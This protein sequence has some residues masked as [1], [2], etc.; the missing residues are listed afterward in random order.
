[1]Y[2]ANNRGKRLPAALLSALLL[3]TAVFPAFQALAA[4]EGWLE[5]VHVEASSTIRTDLDAYNLIDGDDGT[6][7]SSAMRDGE[8]PSETDNVAF[9]VDGTADI[10]K[11]AITPR[12]DILTAFP[13]DFK[14][15]YSP[16]KSTWLDIPGQT[17]TDYQVTPGEKV[18][19]FQPVSAKRIR[20]VATRYGQDDNGAYL[21]QLGEVR[22]YGVITAPANPAIWGKSP[23]REPY[24]YVSEGSFSGKEQ[25][26]SPDPLV[27]YRWD[28]PKAEDSLE[29]FLQK[30]KTYDTET[31][32]S[33]AGL[34]TITTDD[35]AITV[36]GPGT[37]RMDFGTEFAGWLEIDSPDL[38]GEITLG[39]SEYNQPAFVNSG[40]KSPS[41]TAAP[42]K[43]GD[44]Y[45]LELNDELYEG[46]R[47]GFINVEKFD[48]PF[49]ITGVRL[50]CQTKPVN[51]GGSFDSDNEMLNK[52]WYTAAYD[53]RANLKKDYLAAILVDRGDRHS[54]TGDA[55][56]SQAA[57]LVAFGNYDFILE[58]LRYTAVRPNGIESYELYWLLSLIDYYE[59]SGDTEGVLSLLDE[60]VKRL[61]HAYEIYGT[62]PSL[63]FFGWDERLGAGFENPNLPENQNSYKLL[64]IQCWKECAALFRE[65]GREDLADTYQ[66]YAEEKTAELTSDPDFYKE[67]GLHASADA[68]NAGVIEDIDKLYHADFDDRLNRISYSPFNQYML[69][70]AMGRAG[71]YDDA[72]SAILDL[73]GGQVEY[74]G[75][76][77]FETF[78]P[79]WND[80]LEE[81]APV[82]NNQAGY[83]SLAHP[84][85]AG[86]LAWM[87]EE[88]LGIKADEAGFSSFTV[89]PHLGRQLTRVS[90]GTPTPYGTI[91]AAFDVESGAHAVT[92]PA[93]TTATVALPKVEKSITDITLNGS[94]AAPS[95]EDEDFVY[96]TGLSAGTYNFQV[97]YEG[98]TPAYEESE[99]VY[100]A[101]FVGRDTTTKGSWG[102]VYGSEGYLLPGYGGNDVRVLPDY[103]SNVRLSKGK[104]ISLVTDSDDPRALSSNSF[105]AG[106]RSLGAYQSDDNVAC[107]QTFTVDID[108]REKREYTVAL[109]FADWEEEGREQMVEMFDGD[110][111]NLVAPLQ[112][113][114]D[115]EGGVYLIYKYDNSARF[116]IN[117]IRGKNATLSGI[118]FG[119]GAGSGPAFS[120]ELVDDQDAR[121]QYTGSG[122]RHDPMG[123]AYNGTFS[124]T[125]TPGDGAEFTF[126]GIGISLL[127]SMESNR[128]IAEIFFDGESMG[129]FD[130]YSAGTRR[131]EIVFADNDLTY[132]EHTIKIVATGEKNPLAL[133]AYV[134]VDAFEVRNEFQNIT[135][136]RVDDQQSQVTFS[137]AGW[138]HDPM[139]GTYADTFSYSKQAGD[140]AVLT[141]TGSGISYIA[142]RE[143]NR[144]IAEIFVDDVSQGTVDLYSAETLR[145]QTVFTLDGLEEGEHTI[146]V[147]VTGEKNPAASDA[148]VDVDAFAVRS[149]LFDVDA[150]A[151]G[152]TV[153]SP[154]PGETSLTLPTLP[155]GFQLSIVETSHPAVLDTDGHITT[156][157]IDMAVRLLLRVSDGK[158]TADREL[159]VIVPGA[160][161][162]ASTYTYDDHQA[163]IRY[164][165]AGWTHDPGGINVYRNTYTYTNAAGATASLTFNGTG[166]T[167]IASKTANRGI[168][169]IFIDGES[170]GRVDCYAAEPQTQVEVFSIDNLPAGEHTL[171]IRATGEK[172]E[173]ADG[174]YVEV[175]AIR[176]T[177]PFDNRQYALVDEMNE[178]VSAQGSGWSLGNAVSG[179]YDATLSYSNVPGDYME[180]TF[181][182]TGI[183][184]FAS[185]ES[186][187]GIA[188]II[189]DGVSQGTVDMYSPSILRQQEIFRTDTLA[190][191]QHTL[192]IRVTGQQNPAS[193][194]AYVDV[195]CFETCAPVLD[196]AA[197]VSQLT[198]LP[199]TLGEENLWLP[200]LP[201]GFQL[202]ITGTSHPDIV[203]T[204][205]RI[206]YP[207]Q[208]TQVTL[209][210]SVAGAGARD[211]TVQI[212]GAGHSWDAD[213]TVDKEP[214]CTEAG[215]KSIHCKT[216]GERKEVTV[217][218][219]LGHAYG[220]WETVEEP[221]CTEEGRE[222][223]TCSRCKETETRALDASHSW[224]AEYTVDKEATCTEAGSKSIHCQ[225]CDA[226]QNETS[227]DPLGHDYGP[228]ET[229]KEPTCTEEGEEARTCSRCKE[230]EIRTLTAGHVWDTEYTVDREPTCTETGSKSI[231]CQNCDAVQDETAIDPL[232]HDFGQWVVTE[233]AT[234][235]KEGSKER[236]CSRCAQKETAV[237]EKLEDTDTSQTEPTTGSDQTTEPDQSEIPSDSSQTTDAPSSA[238]SQVDPPRQDN[239]HQQETG[240]SPKTG[241]VGPAAAMAVLIL[242]A[243]AVCLRGRKGN[244]K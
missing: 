89:K 204:D 133:D 231:H 122:W 69:L 28:N 129:T 111:L 217:I 127:A 153:R 60:A 130:L 140:A 11:I 7:W 186:N 147:V 121:V 66:G 123:D 87:S 198:L 21:M 27:S 104:R 237:I 181:T 136:V 44:T 241:E 202:A 4:G 176:V 50:V 224:D 189:L 225:K 18:F 57:S 112:A 61:D 81:N 210:L 97:T 105:N 25:P 31:P 244:A 132:G 29:I 159:Y 128:G 154:Q 175:D 212:P 80:I 168:A 139:G 85:S 141:F 184:C 236:V 114:R 23:I 190:Y 40:P 119:E 39:M 95:S 170:Y 78:R 230:T 34:Q 108:L 24:D 174:T 62:N 32:D 2:Q 38:S 71:E 54:W 8:Y 145:Q 103:V 55:Y 137:G 49:T 206:T 221:T 214:T 178:A 165:G 76:T 20:I 83:T 207:E 180:Y 59:Y 12:K 226:V 223:R 203:D 131:Q 64:S 149:A 36:N 222:E 182:G 166:L 118:F 238:E 22:L 70:Q 169:E 218:D 161:Y 142:S 10:S 220:S 196:A 88:V 53:V 90:G 93:G 68:I 146:R 15:Q 242:S 232:G 183:A 73:W 243:A 234:V 13:R 35:V 219:P 91:Q 209:T 106:S 117:Q 110:T 1:M 240:T 208:D 67:Y 173:A 151:A 5:I 158:D 51:Y 75:T 194:G 213:F 199:P 228:W 33:F 195:D 120:T 65:L 229:V 3:L 205:G 48:K 47:F 86:V 191:G 72:I 164:E 58:N 152:L 163:A 63:G 177:G 144:G 193:A 19:T 6:F 116:R 215:S 17:Y 43:Y 150:L 239:T 14:L 115:F 26:A 200:E 107:Y 156:P 187:R 233:E 30:P 113:V 79:G 188:E 167:Y 74:G 160:D 45:R 46:V 197:L 148:Y 126:T 109:Y 211:L 172:N 94:P 101:E 41:K 155:S 162:A 227:I 143:N 135:E 52:I 157:A 99:Y 138:T 185:K 37:I 102:G 98:Q 192:Q 9:T 16:D 56:T 216:C 201:A 134:D 82:P 100:P 179:S 84:W 125:N 124:Y 42:V 92:V 171:Q 96:F 77:F 235:D